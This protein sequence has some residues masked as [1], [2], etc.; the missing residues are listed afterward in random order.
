[1]T[2]YPLDKPSYFFFQDSASEVSY[3]SEG[4]LWI[5]NEYENMN[6]MANFSFEWY[7]HNASFLLDTY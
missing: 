7:S 1:M 6:K 3:A 5:W 4:I 2:T